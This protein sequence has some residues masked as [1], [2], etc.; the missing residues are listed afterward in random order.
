MHSNDLKA[1][2]L[3]AVRKVTSDKNRP[4]WMREF[5]AQAAAEIERGRFP[6][7]HAEEWKYTNVE[8]FAAADFLRR[9]Q[10][11]AGIDLNSM[12]KR[13]IV[14]LTAPRLVFI[15]GILIEK[16][17][18]QTGSRGGVRIESLK[19]LENAGDGVLQAELGQAAVHDRNFFAAL[20][21]VFCRDGAVVDVPAQCCLEEP[22]YLVFV[23]TDECSV[24]YP[25][26]LIRAG[27][28]SS[29]KVVEVYTGIGSA[30]TWTDAVT[31]INCGDGAMVEHYLVQQE[32]SGK[33]HI[34]TVAAKLGAKARFSAHAITLSGA[35][36]RNNIHVVLDGEGAGCELN[37]LYL[38]FGDSHVD[39]F[40]VIDHA[41]PHC[42]SIELYK[43]VLSGEAHGVFNGK[44]IVRQDAQKSEARQSNKNLLLSEH[45]TVNTN[46]QLEIYADDVKCTHGSAVG[47]IDADALFYLRSRGLDLSAAKSLLSF[48]FAADIVDRLKI[49][50]LRER[51]NDY[52]ADKF[53]HV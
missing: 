26:I 45:A 30:E 1:P 47:Q 38:G 28:G 49:T 9:P 42:S 37:G 3:A 32:P 2:I 17:V 43:G 41:R 21:S 5:Q 31:E 13:S 10:P 20:N 11:L 12:L 7:T 35:L 52:L 50:N 33:G 34:G 53:R 22:I 15:D 51:L 36:V 18:G 46:P 4:A 8:A 23:S 25:R 40:T 16:N 48:A 6:S 27:S 44:I 39:N 24:K 19:A 29:V 14:D